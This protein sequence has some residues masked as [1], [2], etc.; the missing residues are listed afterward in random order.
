MWLLKFIGGHID[1]RQYGG[2]KGNSITHYLVEFVNFILANQDNRSPTAVL[3]CMVDFSKAFNRQNHNILIAKLSAM[4]VPSW[5][6]KIVIA[7][8]SK[9]S[10]IVRYKGA[11][12]SQK[13]L[14]GHS[15]WT[16]FIHCS[17]K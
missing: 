1:F 16:D 6:L 5:L 11:K 8:L 13:S 3:A 4:G 2:M 9:R 14:P 15:N 17:Y 12:Y 7:F 10:I